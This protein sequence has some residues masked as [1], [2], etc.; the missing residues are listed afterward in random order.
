RGQTL[1][2]R[3]TLGDPTPALLV[4][5]GAYYNDTGGNW[6]FVVAP[7]GDSAVKRQVRMGRRNADFIEV[8]EGLEAGERVITSPYSGFADKDRLDLDS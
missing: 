8:L 5:N 2:L 7:D 6:V 4:P 3:L 1:Q